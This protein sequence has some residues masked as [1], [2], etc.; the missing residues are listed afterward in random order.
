MTNTTIFI[1][2]W[3]D[4]GTF[5][6]CAEGGTDL[7]DCLFDHE[8][9]PHVGHAMASFDDQK[10]ELLKSMAINELQG[11]LDKEFLDEIEAA[12][13]HTGGRVEM[14]PFS[15]GTTP[16]M[17]ARQIWTLASPEWDIENPDKRGGVE[18]IT[19]LVVEEHR[20]F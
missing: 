15:G 13:W 18:P 10:L 4:Y 7:D 19:R 16:K 12:V 14:Q 5:A 3:L 17:V 11:G 2:S 8:A 20:V 1:A 6:A 9:S